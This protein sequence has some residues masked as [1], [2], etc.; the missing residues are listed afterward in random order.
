MLDPLFITKVFHIS[1]KK[2]LL[3][4]PSRDHFLVRLLLHARSQ[5][6]EQGVRTNTPPPGKSQRYRVP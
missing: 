6:E 1:S 2:S 3:E 5:R 4:M